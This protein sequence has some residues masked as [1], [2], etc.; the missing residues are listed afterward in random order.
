M[1][2]PA[3]DL[4][5]WREELEELDRRMLAAAARRSELVRRIAAAKE[6]A[7]G[8]P[9][10][11]RERERM[12]HDRAAAVADSI[13]LP[14]PVARQL[15][16]VV[17]EHSHD[18]QEQAARAASLVQ[19]ADDPKRFLLVGGGG[20][21]GASF[22]RELA[23][24]GHRID[25]LEADDHDRRAERVRTAEIVLLA[26]PMHAVNAVVAELGP[27]VADDALLCDINSLK[28]DV[29]RA[30]ATHCKGEV[31][32]LH[33]MFGPT[34]RSFRRQKMVVCHVQAGPRGKWLLRE[35]GRMGLELIE[36]E[37]ETHDRMMAVVQVLVHFSTLVLG[38]ALHDV[39]IGIEE[40][41]RFTSPIYR[42]ELAFIG[43]L[44]AQS[45]DLYAEI[46]MTNPHGP[47][48]RR[49]FRQAAEELDRVI[50]DGDRDRFR[51]A[52]HEV[53]AYFDHF[54]ED[55]MALSDSI[56]DMVVTQP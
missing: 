32:G 35:F 50:R 56:I 55:A 12:V 34:V 53:S 21:M 3:D 47:D 13:G 28:E 22:A 52:F 45:A 27:H 39:G 48:A 29:C 43:R 19:T 41:L 9:L 33:P 8:K 36:T 5:R 7:G 10:F 42:L 24:R 23:A 20:R 40:S 4:A 15:M 54:A 37:P 49:A 2:D 26:V 11:D 30:M 1:T 18:I 16:Q 25:I 17:I 51:A 46:E 6:Q 14:R 38:R 44:F 31:L